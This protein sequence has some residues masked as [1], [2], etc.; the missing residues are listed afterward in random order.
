MAR[1]LACLALWALQLSLVVV[2]ASPDWLVGQIVGEKAAV[3][4][5]LGQA[6]ARDLSLR[7]DALYRVLIVDSGLREA[8]EAALLPQ[9]EETIGGQRVPVIFEW[10]ARVLAS[11]WLVLYQ[12]LYRTLLLAGWMPILG[13]VLAAA[14]IDGAVGRQISK[15]LERY[16]NPVRYRAG[17]RLLLALMVVPLFYL[18]VPFNVPPVLVPLWFFAVAAVVIVVMTNAQHRI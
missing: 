3:E 17:A 9:P 5:Y 2:F 15:S 11:F 8:L 18:S 10:M 13:V 14:I 12:M 1:A 4:R 16:A 6:E 7:C